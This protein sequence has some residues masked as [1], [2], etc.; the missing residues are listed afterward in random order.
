MLSQQQQNQSSYS[1]PMYAMLPLK[2]AG[3]AAVLAF[4]WAGLGHVYLGQIGKGII[5]MIMYIVLWIIGIVT[6]I[7]L[8]LV[9][10][11]WLWQLYDAYNKAN[12]YNNA[13]QQTGRAPW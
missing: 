12:E 5:Y 9:L 1:Q 3:I 2:N 10:I 7:G 6:L 8:I 13:L 11:F 4:L